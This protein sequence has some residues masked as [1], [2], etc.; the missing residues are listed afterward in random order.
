MKEI[1]L[2][3]SIQTISEDLTS[4]FFISILIALPLKSE[5]SRTGQFYRFQ[6]NSR[7]CHRG[8]TVSKSKI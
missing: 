6:A 3:F 2:L 4:T 8:N 1:C 7:L 5:L